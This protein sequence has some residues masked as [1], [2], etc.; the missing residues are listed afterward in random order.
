MSLCTRARRSTRPV[1]ARSAGCAWAQDIGTS[2][3]CGVEASQAHTPWHAQSPT[4]THAGLKQPNTHPSYAIPAASRPLPHALF[5]LKGMWLA[6]SPPATLTQVPAA[7]RPTPD[8]NTCP[9]PPPTPAPAACSTPAPR[10]AAPAHSP[11]TCAPA[12]SPPPPC[13]KCSAKPGSCGSQT[14]AA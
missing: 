10:T 7:S 8:I 4:R 12:P 5:H 3:A 11:A 2:P 13:P 6:R 9:A 14:T 1:A